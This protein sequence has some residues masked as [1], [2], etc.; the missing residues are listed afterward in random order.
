MKLLV[1]SSIMLALTFFAI[2]LSR[3]AQP[4]LSGTTADTTVAGS[5]Q[6]SANSDVTS[7]LVNASCLECHKNTAMSPPS[8][9]HL[10]LSCVSCHQ[11][12]E[13]E[14]QNSME[15]GLKACTSACHGG[16]D[17]GVSHLMGDELRNKTGITLTC[18][19]ACHSIHL[20]N[21]SHLLRAEGSDVCGD[22]HVE[23]F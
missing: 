4:Q 19:S 15:L 18:T 12:H 11:P 8:G 7:R 9:A 17:L 13:G 16:H 10:T 23:K 5:P 20:P 6:E 22:C 3:A 21:F 2:T 1:L 14:P